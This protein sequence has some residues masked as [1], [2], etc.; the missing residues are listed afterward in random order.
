MTNQQEIL[1][2]RLIWAS[3]NGHLEI[4]RLLLDRGAYVQAM[5]DYAL[6]WASINGHLEVVRLLL[7]KG[8]DVHADDDD[9]LRWASINGHL[10]VVKVL[11][12]HI[13]KQA[14]KVA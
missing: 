5:D 2:K 14:L 4:V 9:A 8:A 12:E 11:E 10:E 1:N 6:R 13:R 3:T 7:D